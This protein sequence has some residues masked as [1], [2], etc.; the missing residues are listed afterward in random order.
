[1]TT[2]LYWLTLTVLMTAVMWLPY[3]L[4]RI[5]VRGL[6]AAVTDTKAET[7]AEQSEWGKRAMRA[8]MNAV[9]GL[10]IMAP[11][12]LIAHALKITTPEIGTAVMVYF[13]ARLAHY[14]V[15]TAGIPVLRTLTFAAGW[16]CQMIVILAV[17]GWL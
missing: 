12:V 14:L 3:I 9:E 2:E 7:G 6:V 15:Y 13:F 17:L 5:I 8:H 1:M 10:V 4:D 16:V 11:A